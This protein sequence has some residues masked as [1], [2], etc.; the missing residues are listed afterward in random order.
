MYAEIEHTDRLTPNTATSGAWQTHPNMP[1]PFTPP[2]L[3]AVDPAATQAV[4]RLTIADLRLPADLVRARATQYTA[5][6]RAQ[7]TP[8][9]MRLWRVGYQQ[10]MLSLAR[11]SAG[12]AKDAPCLAFFWQQQGREYMVSATFG[13]PPLPRL[14]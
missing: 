1:R 8:H 5:F 14:H 9:S 6:A 11:E 3:H 4:P 2:R 12:V 13:Q 7:G 10:A